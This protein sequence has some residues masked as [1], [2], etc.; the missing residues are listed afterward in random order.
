MTPKNM[1]TPAPPPL[2]PRRGGSRQIGA[3]LHELLGRAQGWAAGVRARQVLGAERVPA[4]RALGR[5][6]PGH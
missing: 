2:D 4:G 1:P 3:R 5:L 6:R